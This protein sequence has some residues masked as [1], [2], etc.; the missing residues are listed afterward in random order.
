MQ[1]QLLNDFTMTTDLE[2]QQQPLPRLRRHVGGLPHRP[3]L[4]E[5]PRNRRFRIA[6]TLFKE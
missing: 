6:A 1:L 4:G 3:R 5:A 2:Q